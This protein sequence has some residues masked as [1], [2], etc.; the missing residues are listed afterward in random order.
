MSEPEDKIIHNQYKIKRWIHILGCQWAQLP[1]IDSLK[2]IE[3]VLA[4]HENHLTPFHYIQ[5]R[6]GHTHNLF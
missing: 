3:K 2:E 6:D 1:N 4:Y 5:T